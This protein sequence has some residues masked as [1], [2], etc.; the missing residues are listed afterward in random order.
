MEKIPCWCTERNRNENCHQY[1]AAPPVQ[2]GL[3][4]RR[5]QIAFVF[6][7]TTVTFVQLARPLDSLFCC[8]GVGSSGRRVS[9]IGSVQRSLPF[10]CPITRHR[11]KKTRN[12]NKK[13][14]LVLWSPLPPLHC[15]TCQDFSPPNTASVCV[16]LCTNCTTV[17]NEL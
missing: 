9:R 3:Q 10:G 4:C 2:L 8:D 6:V 7:L 16:C 11:F 15:S 13:M 1:S 5:P 17:G 12:N 14:P